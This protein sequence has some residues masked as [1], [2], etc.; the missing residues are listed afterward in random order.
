MS[1]LRP[2]R[3]LTGDGPV[4]VSHLE[5]PR[6]PLCSIITSGVFRK[7]VTSLT[8]ALFNGN[9]GLSR[10]RPGTSHL[11][12]VTPVGQ[13]RRIGVT[14]MQ[15]NTPGRAG[16]LESLVELVAALDRCV[17]QL[18]RE[19]GRQIAREASELRAEASVRIMELRIAARHAQ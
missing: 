3:R 9:D 19:A 11:I 4:W 14:V 6:S 17:H 10:F 18:E 12:P 16:S 15:Q 7:T 5:H 1:N 13:G 8:E 2:L